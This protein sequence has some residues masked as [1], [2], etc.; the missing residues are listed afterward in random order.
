MQYNWVY[1]ENK[2]QRYY[3]CKVPNGDSLLVFANKN[4]PNLFKAMIQRDGACAM[5]FD[6]KYN[7]EQRKLLAAKKILL[8]SSR[9]LASED[10]EY[11][12]RKVIWCYAHNK[13]EIT[14]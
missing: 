10:V 12:K 2:L 9:L 1:G 13:T 8:T 14:P 7:D 11:M 6:K 5:I 3:E 4:H